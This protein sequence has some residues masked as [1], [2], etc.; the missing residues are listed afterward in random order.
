MLQIGGRNK[1]NGN[2]DTKSVHQ[3]TDIFVWPK[4]NEVFV[5]D[6]YGNRRIIVFDADT[7]AF[8]R[9]W[10]AF[11]N[12]PTDWETI[13]DG[14]PV[15][16]AVTTGEG[17]PPAARGGGGGGGRG[18]AA[19]LPAD[20]TGPGPQQFGNNTPSGGPTH[21]VQIS[22]DGLVYVADRANRRI[23]VFTIAGKYVTQGFVDREGP[24]GQSVA[25][26]SFSADKAQQYLYSADWGNSR[27]EV[28]DRKTLQTLYQFG[29]RSAKPGDFQGVHHVA[30]DSQGNIYTGEVAPG[31]RAQKFVFKGLSDT[32]PPNA[33]TS[34]QLEAQ[35]AGGQPNPGA[36]APA[37]RGG[38]GAGRGR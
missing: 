37:A 33:L 4:T 5:S 13:K 35:M 32:L 30:T 1:S 34:A 23:Q 15:G 24:S 28:L 11:G 3:A 8:K 20:I 22:N 2:L 9:M 10:G 6:G 14:A 12:P 31:A 19:P 7:G 38:R 18:G 29:E 21:S 16:G 17:G 25:G 27:V 26:I 36:G